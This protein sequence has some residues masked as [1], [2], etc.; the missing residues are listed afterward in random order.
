MCNRAQ[1][2]SVSAHTHTASFNYKPGFSRASTQTPY[3]LPVYNSA[4]SEFDLKSVVWLT[5]GGDTLS[6]E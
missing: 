3:I 4:L 5:P 2:I 6:L 1:F